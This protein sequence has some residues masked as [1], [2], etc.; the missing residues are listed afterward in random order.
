M[1][2]T[3]VKIGLV[4]LLSASVLGG[5]STWG[6][7]KGAANIQQQWDQER[8]T[9]L[10][11]ALK[12]EQ[13]NRAKEAQHRQKTV[14]L[15]ALLK[16]AEAQYEE[17]LAT[18]RTDYGDWL[19]TSNERAARY[20]LWSEASTSERDRLADHAAKLDASLAEGR[21]VVAEFRV[22][23]GQCQRDLKALGEQITLDR[24]LIEE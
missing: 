5:V 17:A 2:S 22:A 10:A 20:R 16:E 1:I 23:L 24:E 7:R 15:E 21:E 14:A 9:L 11:A 13:D 18:V 12:V 6:Y 4:L 3:P 19:R 8:A